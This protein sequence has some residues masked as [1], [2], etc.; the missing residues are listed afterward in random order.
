M[1]KEESPLTILILGSGGR[2][3]SIAKS[4]SRSPLCQ[5]VIAAPGNGGM[6][7]EFECHPVDLE[8]PT[9]VVALARR[10]EADLVVIG[11]EIPLSLGA[12]DAL[13]EAGIHAFG[14]GRDAARLEAS[15]AFSKDFFKRHGIPTAAYGTFTEL[16]P[17]LAF[18]REQ[19]LPVVVKA[20]GLA[21]GK[22]VVIAEYFEEAEQTVRDMLEGEAFG[23][24]GREVVI[25]SFLE[26]EEVSVHLL[27]SGDSALLFP[28]SQ[29]HKRV[30]E[31]D[32]GLNTGGMGAYAPADCFTPEIQARVE[33][34]IIAPTLA[35]LRKD[36][37]DYRGAL[38]IGLMLTEEGPK[39]LEFNVRFG[40]PETQVLLPLVAD[41][42]VALFLACAR[43]DP[44]PQKC[45]FHPAYALV[46]V[47]A[48]AGYP[49]S[50]PKG[51][52]I[53]LPERLIRSAEVVHAGSRIDPE[54]RLVTNGGRVLGAIGTGP[55][56]KIAAAKAYEIADSI[57]YP[58][59]FLRRDIGWRQLQRRRGRR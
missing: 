42:P 49:G 29:D 59:K 36:G 16:D 1:S 27:V 13:R 38:Y 25:E 23:D 56:L 20:S 58:S 45:L 32:T 31:G 48:A 26:G 9:A 19:K 54:N 30:G 10:V 17:A 22:G 7:T 2:E 4:C 12:A 5:K 39:V 53:S 43:G 47:L 28:S 15:K 6:R 41:D 37:L 34:T 14:P 8:D 46:V 21:A 18:L 24:S 57:S 35:G 51:E 50:Y 40:D 33:S 55:S 3:H 44:L 52:P 11:P